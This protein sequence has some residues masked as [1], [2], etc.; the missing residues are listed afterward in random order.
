M[1][2]TN[3]LARCLAYSDSSKQKSAMSIVFVIIVAVITIEERYKDHQGLFLPSLLLF[4]VTK[5]KPR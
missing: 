1:L 5:L 4:Q 2:F 3:Q